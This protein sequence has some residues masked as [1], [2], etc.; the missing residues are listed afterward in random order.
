MRKS[1]NNSKSDTKDKRNYEV[2][3]LVRCGSH[4]VTHAVSS[5]AFHKR[6]ITKN[7]EKKSSSLVVLQFEV[8]FFLT[9]VSFLIDLGLSAFM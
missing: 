2:T 8:I 3:L 9:S 1:D 7:R 6:E 5:C 4:C